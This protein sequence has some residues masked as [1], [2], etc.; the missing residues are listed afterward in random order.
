MQVL[1]WA[2]V[3]LSTSL[4]PTVPYYVP[5]RI[6]NTNGTAYTCRRHVLA[7]YSLQNTPQLRLCEFSAVVWKLILP[8]VPM[9]TVWSAS[10]VTSVIFGHLKISLLVANHTCAGR[11]IYYTCGG[12]QTGTPFPVQSDQNHLWTPLRLSLHRLSGVTNCH[13]WAMSLRQ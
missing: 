1:L 3:C 10:G 4:N 9:P 6:F 2:G 13:H 7:K 8:A 12:S 11:I 5:H